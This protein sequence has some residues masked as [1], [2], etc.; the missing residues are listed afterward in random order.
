MKNILIVLILLTG[1]THRDNTVVN[2]QVPDLYHMAQAQLFCPDVTLISLK[3]YKNT[4]ILVQAQGCGQ[5]VTY[6][7]RLRHTAI[8]FHTTRNSVWQVV[9][10]PPL[11]NRIQPVVVVQ[12]TQPQVIQQN[13]NVNVYQNPPPA[14]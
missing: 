5:I 9:Y 3:K 1:C 4:P 6:Q 14:N 13:V 8:F 12:P 11:P 10:A 7:R 2:Y